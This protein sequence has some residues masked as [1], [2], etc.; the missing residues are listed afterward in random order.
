MAITIIAADNNITVSADDISNTGNEVASYYGYSDYQTMVD[1]YGKELNAELGYEVLYQKV[2]EFLNTNA[3][4]TEGTTADASNGAA[5][6][7][8]AATD[9]QT[10]SNQ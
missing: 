10:Q 7:S 5:D 4:E 6:G 2:Q 9:A 8:D 3:V 1:K